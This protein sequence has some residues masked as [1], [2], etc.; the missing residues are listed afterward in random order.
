MNHI[1]NI[2]WNLCSVCRGSSP[3]Q[4]G[5]IYKLN[6]KAI[7]DTLKLSVSP[8]INPKDVIVLPD[9]SI[10]DKLT[11]IKSGSY[12]DIRPIAGVNFVCLDVYI[13][14]LLKKRFVFASDTT[15]LQMLNTLNKYYVFDMN[16]D[17]IDDKIINT[18]KSNQNDDLGDVLNYNSVHKIKIS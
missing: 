12:I 6:T 17:L 2:H 5:G 15:F 14:E 4:Y 7:E 3:F 11:T 8:N 16:K 10:D 9:S 13:K 18:Y 1:L